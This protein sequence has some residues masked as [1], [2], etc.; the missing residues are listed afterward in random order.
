MKV[1]VTGG[2]GFIGS[3][4]CER[5]SRDP[6]FD[7]VV[8]LDDLSSGFADNLEGMDVELVVGSILDPDVLD[9]VC[10][11]AAAIVH[12]A[13]RGSVPKSVENP[14]ESHDRNATGTLQVLEA[15]RR[16][17][18]VHTIVSS[19]SSVYGST[20]DLPKHEDLPTRPMSPYAVSKVATEW[21]TL[22]YQH[23]YGLP[24]LSFRFF[25][26]YGPRQ[27]AGHAYAAVIPAWISA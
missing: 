7:E 4:L 14:L 27:P 19:S 18:G 2:A 17:G 15:A 9:R 3:N 12:L 13:A 20:P 23:S 11:G 25:N 26:V 5:L 24:T 21:Y 1:V 6:E 10:A 8:A 22:A 16:A